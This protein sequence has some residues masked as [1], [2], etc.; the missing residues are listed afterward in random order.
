MY[1]LRSI[2]AENVYKINEINE[3]E[4]DD[5]QK[6]DIYVQKTYKNCLCNRKD[7]VIVKLAT[8]GIAQF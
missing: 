3:K 4:T 2:F 6:N 8:V 1:F 5:K 7:I